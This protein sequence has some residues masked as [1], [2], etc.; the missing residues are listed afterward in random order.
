[1]ALCSVI[2]GNYTRENVENKIKTLDRELWE[3][4]NRW[5]DAVEE[6]TC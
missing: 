5:G 6:V 3:K 4:I 1:M 2:Y